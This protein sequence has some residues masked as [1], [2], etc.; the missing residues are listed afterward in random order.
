MRT[1][2]ILA[3]TVVL[4][5]SGCAMSGRPTPGPDPAAL[6]VG[7]FSRYPILAPAAVTESQGRVLESVRMAEAMADPEAVDPA[8][9]IPLGGTRAVP[10]PTPAKAAGLLANPVA[11]VLEKRGMLAGFTVGGTDTVAARR[12]TVGAGRILQIVVLRFPDSVAA[13]QAAQEM[14]AV[15]FAVSPDNTAVA[16]PGHA[17]ARA[18]WRPAVPTLAATTAHDVFV[19][20][21]LAGERTPDGTAL[22]TL[23][24]KA[25]DTQIPLLRE[26]A[27]TPAGRFTELAL[28]RDGML[29]RMVPEAPGRWPYPQVILGERDGN[30]GW[31]TLLQVRGIVYGPRGADLYMGPEPFELL[32]LNR[33]DMLARFADAAAAHKHFAAIRGRVTEGV[34]QLVPAPAGLTDVSCSEHLKNSPESMTKF[35]CVLVYGRY[36]AEIASRDYDDVRQ[37]TAAQF[38]LLVNSE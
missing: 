37:R 29:G 1:L 15:D 33:F 18:H 2:R 27:P 6:D 9:T 38:A 8:L 21:V 14:D 13:Q 3:I 19:I 5:L 20:S 32:A 12:G 11:A 30:A 25:F 26:F 22:A 16:I 28:D 7:S 17:S 23:A 35:I 31:D 34:S 24:A 36:L 4:A 10:L